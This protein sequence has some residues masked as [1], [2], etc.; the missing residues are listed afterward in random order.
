MS[1]DDV[2]ARIA[3]VGIELEGPLPTGLAAPLD[4]EM[5]EA[6]DRWETYD[7]GLG[8]LL[9]A[10][11]GEAVGCSPPSVADEPCVDADTGV[12]VARERGTTSAVWRMQM[13][14]TSHGLPGGRR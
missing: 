1:D 8:L 13:S 7:L 14:Q 11:N 10:C 4:Q 6:G 12:A 3:S 9:R 2:V 5:D